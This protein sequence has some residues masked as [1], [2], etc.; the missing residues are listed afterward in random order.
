MGLANKNAAKKALAP[1]AQRAKRDPAL[2]RRA[3]A[4]PGLRSKLPDS[5]LPGAFRDQREGARYRADLGDV[6]TPLQGKHAVRAAR[7]IVE[8]GY[9]GRER[10]MDRQER[11]V[12]AERDAQQGWS[13]TYDKQAQGILGSQLQGQQRSNV[14]AKQAAVDA[15][16]QMIAGIGGAQQGVDQRATQDAAVRGQ[17]LDGGAGRDTLQATSVANERAAQQGAAAAQ[18]TQMRGDAQSAFLRGLAG[19]TSQRGQEAQQ[20]I[21]TRASNELGKVRD[22]RAAM[23][24]DRER[25]VADTLLKLRGNERDSYLAQVGLG[26]TAANNQ[27][28]FTLGQSQLVQSAKDKAA[29][30]SVT[31]RGQ[32][33]SASE[34]AADRASRERTAA[35]RD[36]TT[37]RGQ[38]KRSDKDASGRFTTAALR[39]NA[40]ARDKALS[41]AGVYASNG[42]KDPKKLTDAL[43]LD[44]L[45]PTLVKAAVEAVRGGVTPAT[46]K[47]VKQKF[48]IDIP[49][50]SRAK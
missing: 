31:R 29:G 47:A 30:R 24:V 49:R 32:T 14:E 10:T 44:N 46:A 1:L 41:R 4:N 16:A 21:G 7:Q 17:G 12:G 26:N 40:K 2:L 48:G 22:D 11:K 6:T 37:R 20:A 35:Q 5:M 43:V 34:R 9:A 28:D 50:T 27:M 8:S 36:A 13:A 18:D 15:R 45:D 33:L 39:G 23:R 3:L 25:D 42:V 38:D 19:V